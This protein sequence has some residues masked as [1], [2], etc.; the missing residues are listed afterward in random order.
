MRALTITILA[1]AFAAAAFGAAASPTPVETESGRVEIPLEVYQ[2]LV[3]AGRQ[4]ALAPAGYALGQAN[5]AVR[6]TEASGKASAEI[7]VDLTIEVLEDRWVLVPI[8]PA[9]TPAPD[10]TPTA[11]PPG[12]RRGKGAGSAALR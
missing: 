4:P 8:L 2:Q 7:A 1:L 6:V 5:L 11:T 10:T 3:E 9:G 12:P